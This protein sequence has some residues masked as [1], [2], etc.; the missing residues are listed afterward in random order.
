MQHKTG[1]VTIS[2]VKLYK[3]FQTPGYAWKWLYTVQYLDGI[4]VNSST[5]G[6]SLKEAKQYA[7]KKA[8][9][10]GHPIVIEWE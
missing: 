5:R 8:K 7:T 4:G 10:F 3:T 2:R 1:Q 9:E 6:Y